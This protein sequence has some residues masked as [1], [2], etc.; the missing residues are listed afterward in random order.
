MRHLWQTL[1]WLLA[2]RSLWQ[3]MQSD[4]VWKM[5]GEVIASVAD[6]IPW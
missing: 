4:M 6:K 3:R 2:L 5:S 1:H